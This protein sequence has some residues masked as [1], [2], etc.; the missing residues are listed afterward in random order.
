MTP[1]WTASGYMNNGN[2]D[3]AGPEPVVVI[4]SPTVD[5]DRRKRSAWLSAQH[6]ATPQTVDYDTFGRAFR[7]CDDNGNNQICI[8]TLTL[9][10]NGNMQQMKDALGRIGATTKLLQHAQRG[11]IHG[12]HRLGQALDTKQCGRRAVKKLGQ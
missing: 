8:T 3:P 10:M 9:D 7:T 6:V 4:T 5:E 2:P 12:K 11:D 1:V